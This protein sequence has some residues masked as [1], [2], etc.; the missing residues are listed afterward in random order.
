MRKYGSG[1]ENFTTLDKQEKE[2]KSN[3]NFKNRNTLDNTGIRFDRKYVRE[4]DIPI[5]VLYND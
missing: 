5:E 4:S 3:I 1:F 2:F